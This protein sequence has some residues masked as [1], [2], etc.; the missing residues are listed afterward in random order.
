[1]KK[2]FCFLLAAVLLVS[3]CA[4][5]E[6]EAAESDEA[7]SD[8][9]SAGLEPEGGCLLP[10]RIEILM[11]GGAVNYA[12][13]LSY[14]DRTLTVS[15]GDRICCVL[16]FDEA[17]N[18]VQEI[19]CDQNGDEMRIERKYEDG[20]LMTEFI[21]DGKTRV[22]I[23]KYE[24]D[25]N[26]NELVMNRTGWYAERRESEYDANGNCVQQ[27]T[28]H[29]TGEEKRNCVYAY[30]EQG[31]LVHKEDSYDIG[32]TYDYS[33]DAL[34]RL[35]RTTQYYFGVAV[36][37]IGVN[38][39]DEAGRLID[40]TWTD[41]EGYE[42]FERYSYLYDENGNL[43]KSTE[44]ASGDYPWHETTYAYDENG[45]CTERLLWTDLDDE[46]TVKGGSR[47]SSFLRADVTEEMYQAIS[48]FLKSHNYDLP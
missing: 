22:S 24:Y 45:N 9:E 38:T 21:Y 13:D 4:C 7:D 26:G 36:A 46:K 12:V 10:G 35:D 19:V 2:I 15:A 14:A 34:G 42:K 28:Y 6:Q 32:Y 29:D 37:M 5:T 48:A 33:Y 31:R 18:P 39:Y 44:Y 23:A 25:G 43:V 3:L 47:A 17:G 1:M 27:I 11:E 20:L 40:Q 16:E 8:A 41:G 30:D